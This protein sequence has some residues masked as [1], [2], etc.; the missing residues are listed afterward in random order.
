MGQPNSSGLFDSEMEPHS[1][2]PSGGVLPKD[3]PSW[4]CAAWT[5]DGELKNVSASAEPTR[6]FFFF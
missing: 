4:S 5:A 2:A 3:T 6:P 1:F